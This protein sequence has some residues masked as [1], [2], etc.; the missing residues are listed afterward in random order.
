MHMNVFFIPLKEVVMWV[1]DL[2]FPPIL[3]LSGLL[4][5]WKAFWLSFGYQSVKAI[6]SELSAESA[7]G[8]K[9]HKP[10]LKIG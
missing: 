2:T 8:I 1:W 9:K 6:I 7:W 4:E 5:I 3:F 10:Y